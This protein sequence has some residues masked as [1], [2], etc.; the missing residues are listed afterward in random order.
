MQ[1]NYKGI[2]RS[3]PNTFG[4]WV[5][6]KNLGQLSTFVPTYTNSFVGEKGFELGTKYVFAK[7]LTGEIS[8][9]NGKNIDNNKE[10][11]R[12]FGRVEYRF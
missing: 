10:K 5:A 3:E 8:Y 9:F 7:N 11:T 1:L 2:K 12:W 4:T 6:Y